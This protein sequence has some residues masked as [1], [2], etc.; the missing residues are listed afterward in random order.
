VVR[1]HEFSRNDAAA[2]VSRRPGDDGA[3]EAAFWA[4]LGGDASRAS[5]A[6]AL[7]AEDAARD[8][9]GGRSRFLLG[10]LHFYRFGRIV[11]WNDVSDPARAEI[12]AARQ[13]LEAAE[14]A[15]W[16][17][18]E[19][20]D[21]IP[22][23][24]AAAIYHYG[25]AHDDPSEIARGLERLEE[26]I[27]LNPLFNAFN[28]FSLAPVLAPGDPVFSQIVGLVD[29]AFRGPTA[30]CVLSMP[31]FCA[32]EGLAPHN[33]EGSLLLFGDIYAKAARSADAAS[34]YALAAALGEANGWAYV[35]EAVARR[36]DVAGRVARFA[37]GDPADDPAI[38]GTSAAAC[39]GCHAH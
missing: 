34:L 16:D 6:F 8:A 1:A 38:F 14:P 12:A 39:V 32:N 26:A 19:G 18:T 30:G 24:V 29:E 7:L 9:R 37:N 36:D 20:D 21:R 4:T 5:E 23:F 31:D 2:I 15:L 13:A 10:M 27:E 25:V 11:D 17:G 28:L 35:D 22:G 33:L 3:G